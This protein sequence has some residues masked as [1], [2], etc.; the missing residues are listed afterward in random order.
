MA[1]ERPNRFVEWLLI[2]RG[3]YPVLRR[4]LSAWGEA[5]REEPVLIWQTPGVRYGVYSFAIIVL[6]W[7]ASSL[8]NSLAGI[9]PENRKELA[10]TGP[11][12]DAVVRGCPV[13]RQ[14]HFDL[15]FAV[16]CAVVEVHQFSRNAA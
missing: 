1:Q 12:Q 16:C 9:T 14:P 5:V 13:R 15:D 10:T 11:Y 4:K 7:G 6:L 2:A 8:S 3:N